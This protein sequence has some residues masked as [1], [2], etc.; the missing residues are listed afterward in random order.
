[1]RPPW[2]YHNPWNWK[3]KLPIGARPP[4]RFPTVRIRGGT[5]SWHLRARIGQTIS[6][7]DSIQVEG[8]WHFFASIVTGKVDKISLSINWDGS[9]TLRKEITHMFFCLRSWLQ[10]C[11]GFVSFQRHFFCIL[12]TY[13][14]KKRIRVYIQYNYTW[15]SIRLNTKQ[16]QIRN[17]PVFWSLGLKL[18]CSATTPLL[19]HNPCT[20]SNDVA[21][22]GS[23]CITELKCFQPDRVPP[24]VLSK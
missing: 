16:W 4:G 21:D 23:I 3:V 2:N 18:P 19:V 14:Y 20:Q 17:R 5:N 24:G 13:K 11:V 22:A 1:M 6:H 8:T 10:T 7:H 9:E 12:I 15:Y